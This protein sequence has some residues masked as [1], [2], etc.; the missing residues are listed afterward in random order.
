MTS[1]KL[2]TFS[3][4]LLCLLYNFFLASVSL[5]WAVSSSFVDV[6]KSV[7]G[8]FAG[9]DGEIDER[10]R[11]RTLLT[12]DVDVDG[13]KCDGCP[14]NIG[15]TIFSKWRTSVKFIIFEMGTAKTAVICKFP[16]IPPYC[17]NPFF[18]QFSNLKKTVK[19]N[20]YYLQT[21]FLFPVAS[22]RHTLTHVE[23]AK[24]ST[25]ISTSY[26]LTLHP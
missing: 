12:F 16:V 18:S 5:R 25:I 17:S 22:I 13:C 23:S 26:R 11:F 2:A 8:T 3:C 7:F 21:D 4:S 19:S 24:W 10:K 9:I 14:A 15:G 6:P 1:S 20:F